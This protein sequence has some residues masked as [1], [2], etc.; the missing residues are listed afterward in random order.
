MKTIRDIHSL[1]NSHLDVQEVL[2]SLVLDM[3]FHVQ[4]VAVGAVS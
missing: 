1:P 3:F 4:A 2:K